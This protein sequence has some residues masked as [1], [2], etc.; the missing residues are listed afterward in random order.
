MITIKRIVTPLAGKYPQS[1]LYFHLGNDPTNIKVTKIKST[2]PTIDIRSPSSS[3]FGI[4][5]IYFKYSNYFKRMRQVCLGAYE[6]TSSFC[7][8]I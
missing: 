2:V 4:S 7:D 8:C 3:T 1:E 5:I 6:L